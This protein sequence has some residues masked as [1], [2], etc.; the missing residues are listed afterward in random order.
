M[1]FGTSVNEVK[2]LNR[3]GF[4]ISLDHPHRIQAERHGAVI[5]SDGLSAVVDASLQEQ[6]CED[7]DGVVDGPQVSGH[8]RSDPT[9]GQENQEQ[10]QLDKDPVDNVSEEPL[11]QMEAAVDV[12]QGP[13]TGLNSISLKNQAAEKSDMTKATPLLANSDTNATAE[14]SN[15]SVCDA[16][17][18]SSSAEAI[19]EGCTVSPAV[20]SF[21][22]EK[23]GTVSGS[24]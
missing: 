15:H 20:P 24:H 2:A 4:T 16:A 6:S 14:N 7:K 3:C 19:S 8:P 1:C 17:K 11:Q 12:D 13:I 5:T 18:G 9:A 21:G 10:Q 22:S 23:K